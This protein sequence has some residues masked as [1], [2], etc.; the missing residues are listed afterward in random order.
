MHNVVVDDVLA[1]HRQAEMAEVGG[2]LAGFE[3]TKVLVEAPRGHPYLSKYDSYVRGEQRLE[4]NEIQQIGFRV[5]SL[6][7]LTE[8]VGIDVPGEFWNPRIDELSE[9]DA[10]IAAI[11]AELDQV[12]K[13]GVEEQQRLLATST[14]AVVLREMNTQAAGA[15]LLLDYLAY[16]PRI[17]TKDEYL[18]A[19]VT[20]NWY[21]RNLHIF[22]ELLSEAGNGQR[23]LVIFGAGHVPVLRYLIEGSTLFSTHE[24]ADYLGPL[25][26]GSPRTTEENYG[27]RPR[28]EPSCAG[29]H[30]RW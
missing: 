1:P 5:A 26:R 20:A 17:V 9:T 8:V 24:V 14:L 25:L 6:C 11:L 28:S 15:K 19:D 30:Q 29:E 7:G 18:G 4:R 16:L 13:A 12:G 23:L 22:A 3:P 2:A 10:G 27:S 21:R